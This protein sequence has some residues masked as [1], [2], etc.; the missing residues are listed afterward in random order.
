M[1]VRPGCARA[2]SIRSR[3]PPWT[4][5]ASTSRRHRPIT[6]EEL[7]DLEGLNFD[8][9]VTLSPEAHHRALELTRALAFEVEYWPTAD[10]ICGRRQPRAA[11]GC[12]SRHSRP[13]A[14]RGSAGASFRTAPATSS[15]RCRGDCSPHGAKGCGQPLPDCALARQDARG[16]PSGLRRYDFIDR[17][18]GRLIPLVSAPSGAAAALF[19]GADRGWQ[20]KS[21]W[22]FPVL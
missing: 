5:S 12:L 22:N 18:R 1:S 15:R 9:I 11:D 8:L 13:I 21:S 10:P 6:I 3:S 2:S 4:R 17:C 14:A 19:A 16:S 20:K 7:D